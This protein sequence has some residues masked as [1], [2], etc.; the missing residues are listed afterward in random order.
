MKVGDVVT[1]SPE[2]V[3]RG[4]PARAVVSAEVSGETE[5]QADQRF[6][7]EQRAEYYARAN[8]V[9]TPDKPIDPEWDGV[10]L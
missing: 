10:K 8:A 3:A 5:R 1:C 9:S 2:L 6:I 4:W 7:D